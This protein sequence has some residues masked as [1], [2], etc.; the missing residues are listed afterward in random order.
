MITA[1]IKSEGVKKKL[2]YIIEDM[3]T[4]VAIGVNSAMK[5]TRK[6][7]R[8]TLAKQMD[9][10]MPAK[11]FKGAIRPK[12]IA[13]KSR[14]QATLALEKGRAI[15]LRY[16]RPT[17]TKRDGTSVRMNNEIPGKA[18]RTFLPNAFV[19]KRLGNTVFERAF[20]GKGSKRLPIVQ[21]FGPNFGELM[22]AVGTKEAGVALLR[23]E[24]PKRI[25]RRIRFL[26]LRQSG[27]LRGNQPSRNQ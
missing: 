14:L 4:A 23:K 21:Q 13:S 1:T 16:F 11:A 22:K 27:G 15:S 9:V 10:K 18:G 20:R 3:P 7:L 17:Q 19:V 26:L 12:F 25:Q 2:A 24:A 8:K 6:E 5:K